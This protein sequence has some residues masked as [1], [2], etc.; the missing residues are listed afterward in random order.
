MSPTTTKAAMKHVAPIL[1]ALLLLLSP[2]RAGAGE[3]EAAATPN[4]DPIA[5]H[6]LRATSIR[7]QNDVEV[8]STTTTYEWSG[9]RM[10]RT[11][12]T[13]RDGMPVETQTRTYQLADGHG[14]RVV[15]NFNDYDNIETGT[16]DQRTTF[17]YDP[18]GRLKEV[19]VALII[20]EKDWP[21]D[22]TYLRRFEYD[23]EG[24]KTLEIVDNGS[25]DGPQYNEFSYS[26][27]DGMD[28]CVM[29]G[30][31]GFEIVIWTRM[32]S[33][34]P[35]EP[36]RMV[37]QRQQYSTNDVVS[38][39]ATSTWTYDASGRKSTEVSEGVNS[40]LL[41]K[42]TTTYLYDAQGRLD[43]TKE[44][45]DAAQNGQPSISVTTTH[46]HYEPLPSEE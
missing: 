23:Q 46:Y 7:T 45:R 37:S 19:H 12:R 25:T 20:P 9:R 8:E 5:N 14:W 17:E 40:G 43:T 6:V 42:E 33:P 35:G 38:S 31:D 21:H 30:V 29:K 1:I 41:W 15:E 26:T 39:D 44:T 11:R 4:S 28:K 22:I 10:I 32:E 3:E 13:T 16:C 27:E 36:P 34:S 24:R 2:L 18:S